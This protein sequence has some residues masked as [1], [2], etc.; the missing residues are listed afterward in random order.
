MAQ[1]LET[2]AL[3]RMTAISSSS[4]TVAVTPCERAW[5]NRGVMPISYISVSSWGWNVKF[6]FNL[7]LV[8]QSST[9]QVIVPT[10]IK[11]NS[12]TFNQTQ[13]SMSLVDF[14]TS[15]WLIREHDDFLS[16]DPDIQDHNIELLLP[17]SNPLLPDIMK[18]MVLYFIL[19]L[20]LFGYNGLG[21]C[22]VKISVTTF[23]LFFYLTRATDS[24][25]WRLSAILIF[26]LSGSPVSVGLFQLG[27]AH[28]FLLG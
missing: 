17:R 9:H 15:N 23:S 3:S 1:L 11:T 16:T 20:L 26:C 24:Q 19:V 4:R 13:F 18:L 25:P 21:K 28:S 22:Q 5:W 2:Q 6:S 10:I 14:M 8:L 7:V 12:I 27:L